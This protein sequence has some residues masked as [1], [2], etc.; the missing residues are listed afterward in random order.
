MQASIFFFIRIA[1][2]PSL[3][4]ARP[5]IRRLAEERRRRYAGLAVNQRPIPRPSFNRNSAGE[6]HPRRV[7]QRTERLLASQLAVEVVICKNRT[8]NIGRL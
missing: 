2:L 7:F 8:R 1:V 3:Q 6:I 4:A 5:Q